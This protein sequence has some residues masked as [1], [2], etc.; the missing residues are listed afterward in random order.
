MILFFF[1]R[2][3]FVFLPRDEGACAVVL[4]SFFLF[5]SKGG[6]EIDNELCGRKNNFFF[7][8]LRRVFSTIFCP[9]ARMQEQ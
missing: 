7:F 9:D 8:S 1:G 5:G 3:S 4:L 2:C 6:Q